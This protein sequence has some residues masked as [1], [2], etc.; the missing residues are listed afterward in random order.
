[1]DCHAHDVIIMQV[2]EFLS[3]FSFIV[4]DSNG[5]G[6]KDYISFDVVFQIASSIERPE[7]MSIFQ[8]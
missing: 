2:E 8:S 6:C 5:C 3:V 4:N 7:S 1:M